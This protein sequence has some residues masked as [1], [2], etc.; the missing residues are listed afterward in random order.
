MR[1]IAILAIALSILALLIPGRARLAPVSVSLQRRPGAVD[2]IYELLQLPAPAPPYWKSTPG[3]KGETETLVINPRPDSVGDDA[4]LEALIGYWTDRSSL[5]DQQKP[6]PIV[7]KRLLEGVEKNPERLTALLDLLPDTADTH[8]RIKKILDREERT[9]RLSADHKRKAREW[10]MTHSGYFRDELAQA[11]E[12][13]KDENGWIAGESKIKALVRLDWA[14]AEPILKKLASGDQPRAA[15]LA[16]ALLYKRAVESN[17][18]RQEEA[19]RT[20]LKAI[21]ADRRANGYSRDAACDALLTTEWKGRDEWYLS[22]FSDATLRNPQDGY[23]VFSPLA[24]PV[25]T[26]PDQWI[27]VITKLIGNK[28][29]AIHDAAVSCLVR[30]NLREARSDAL[31]PLLPWLSDPKWSSAGDRLRLIQSLEDLNIPEC[32]PGLIHVVEFDDDSAQRSYAAESLAAY[33]DPR[34]IPALKKALAKEKTEHHRARI[35]SAL[36]ICGGLSDADKMAALEAYAAQIATRR[37]SEEFEGYVLD[38][39]SDRAVP[40]EISVG[41]FLSRSKEPADELA[42]KLLARAQTLQE[43]RPQVARALIDIVHSWPGKTGAIDI[44]NRII[45]ARADAK[46][47]MFALGRRETLRQMAEERLRDLAKA[48]GATQGIAVALLGDQAGER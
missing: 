24:T 1:R 18:A 9:P 44:I 23:T 3:K 26:S 37:G 27:P 17:D 4:P 33:R 40:A 12:G 43:A 13:A 10:L 15:A 28:N 16:L 31:R 19:L 21:V 39:G 38:L 22:L 34:A 47:I 36:V 48:S 7:S 46:S 8:D 20:R 2:P 41:Y 32:V 11:A 25:A 6:S 14:R 45:E 29:R 5:T 30:F 35:I 42:A